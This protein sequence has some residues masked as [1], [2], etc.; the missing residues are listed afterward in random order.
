MGIPLS[1]GYALKSSSASI[2]SSSLRGPYCVVSL[3][4]FAF[5]GEISYRHFLSAPLSQPVARRIVLA[6]IPWSSI[7]LATLRLSNLIVASSAL[8]KFP[9]P[10]SPISL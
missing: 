1:S 5:I 2:A 3:I 7:S 9:A 10:S 4:S 8:S 6:S